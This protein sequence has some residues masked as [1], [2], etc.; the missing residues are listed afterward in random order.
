MTSVST[1]L[2]HS[3]SLGMGRTYPL[4]ARCSYKALENLRIIERIVLLSLVMDKTVAIDRVM[5]ASMFLNLM[6]VVL[7]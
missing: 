2:L 5:T 6:A 4:L 7:P 1:I 3:A